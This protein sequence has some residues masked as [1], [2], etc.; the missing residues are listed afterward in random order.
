M[1][2]Y[3]RYP[4]LEKPHSQGTLVGYS[5][6][7]CKKLD[8]TERLSTHTHVVNHTL[9]HTTVGPLVFMYLVAVSLSLGNNT[10][11]LQNSIFPIWD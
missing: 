8:M 4:C 7:G 11:I 6:W 3:S 2:T 5:P 9:L 10:S 1:L